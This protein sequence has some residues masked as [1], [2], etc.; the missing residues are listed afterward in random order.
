L[1]KKILLAVVALVA[2]CLLGGGGFVAYRKFFARKP[3]PAPAAAPAAQAAPGQGDD[4]LEAPSGEEKEGGGGSSVMELK[5]LIVNLDSAHKNAFL[6]CDLHVLFRDPGLARLATSD[7][8][9]PENSV[10]RAVVLQSLSGK[11]VEEAMD[12]ETR[13]ALRQEIKDR[14]N[15][16]FA[17]WHSKEILDQAKKTGKPPQPPIKDVLVVDWAIQ[18]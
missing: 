17:N 3:A 6:K 2:L 5:Q 12:V 13:E 18:Q 16:K 14:L 1:K 8:A 11:T 10:I 9:T 7:K 4:D 15:E